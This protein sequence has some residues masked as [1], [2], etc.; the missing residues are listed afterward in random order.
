MKNFIFLSAMLATSLAANAQAL[1]VTAGAQ[2]ANLYGQTLKTVEKPA[3]LNVKQ[4]VSAPNRAIED[5][6]VYARPAGVYYSVYTFGSQESEMAA[7]L[8]PGVGTVTYPNVCQNPAQA[9]WSIANNNGYTDLNEYTNVNNDLEMSWGINYH[10]D[11]NQWL[12]LGMNAPVISVGNTSFEVPY[13]Q[14]IANEIS[15]MSNV[16]PVR[17]I[18]IRFTNIDAPAYGTGS[19]YEAQLLQQIAGLAKIHGV[20]ESFDKPASP[21]YVESVDIPFF[22]YQ[23]NPLNGKELTIKIYPFGENG[24]VIREAKEV[25]TCNSAEILR[26]Q[27]DNQGRTFWQCIGNFSKKTQDEFGDEIA[28]PFTIDYPYAVEISG[29]NQEGVDV[30]LY[31]TRVEDA[32]EL[33]CDNQTTLACEMSDGSFEYYYVGGEM[34]PIEF[35]MF[36][37]GVEL[38]NSY[39]S[40][41]VSDDGQT[42]LTDNP[43]MDEDNKVNFVPFSS[44]APFFAYD[45]NGEVVGQNYDVEGLPDW[46]GVDGVA[47]DP[48][49]QGGYSAIFFKAEP[50]PAG[51]EGRY[52]T[53]YIVGRGGVKNAQPITVRQG[54]VTGIDTVIAEGDANAIYYNVSGQRVNNAKG[55]VISKTGKRIIK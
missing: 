46:L 3:N 7:W 50:L 17:G 24:Q 40:V 48:R 20:F 18:S 5:G 12:L 11:T 19:A 37:D 32:Y 2:R 34:T 55:L 39:K 36:Y 23:E 54:S 13:V 1:Q 10:N 22:T 26:A 31:L 41:V 9:T 42:C 38:L 47:D 14:A 49:E 25:L 44:A 51:T 52:A 16:N 30:E 4:F 8:V 45:E 21:M 29:Y 28:D 27:T 43:N 6:V 15:P 53:I 33:A 35:N